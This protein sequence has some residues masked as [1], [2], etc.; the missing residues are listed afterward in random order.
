[1][2]ADV[3]NVLLRARSWQ[4]QR[5][6]RRS[7]GELE[8]VGSVFH[9]LPSHSGQTSCCVLV[10]I[11]LLESLPEL[12]SLTLHPTRI[13]PQVRNRRLLCTTC[14]ALCRPVESRGKPAPR[15]GCARENS[16]SHASLCSAHPK[17]LSPGPIQ[18]TG[19]AKQASGADFHS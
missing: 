16:T 1:M 7:F 14:A 18:G 8:R 17:P 10:D 5:V 9:P 6:T 3:S 4:S 15:A 19:S 2:F 11:N 13:F 12:Y